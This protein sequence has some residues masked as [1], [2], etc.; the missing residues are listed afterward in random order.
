MCIYTSRCK[1]VRKRTHNC[2]HHTNTPGRDI[3]LA[4]SHYEPKALPLHKSYR[5]NSIVLRYTLSAI[6]NVDITASPPPRPHTHTHTH[7][8][9]PR[10][11]T[12]QHVLA[13][14]C[15]FFLYWQT[16]HL[17]VGLWTTVRSQPSG[18]Y[19]GHSGCSRLSLSGACALRDSYYNIN[20]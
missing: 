3:N 20:I 19:H 8:Q 7:T 2:V 6:Q 10:L 4:P 17:F 1:A 15:N 12:Y 9:K 16:C 13:R 14:N 18:H 5:Y 11:Y